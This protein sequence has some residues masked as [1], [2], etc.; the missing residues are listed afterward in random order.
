M[1]RKTLGITDDML[2]AAQALVDARA[3]E[4]I[5]RPQVENYQRLILAKH[6]FHREPKYRG[7]PDGHLPITD[8]NKVWLMSESDL[9]AYVAECHLERDRL[10]LLTRD[11]EGCP[12]L[13]AQARRT[14]AEWQLFQTLSLH[15]KLAHLKSANE[16][17][18]KLRQEAL[19]LSMKFLAPFLVNH[20]PSP[21][22]SAS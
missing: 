20:R 15:P 17:P 10:G 18:L 4:A 11:P 6:G 9:A 22:A 5:L 3:R 21:A 8:P 1:D 12:L 7:V 13:E 16:K 14:E 19:D 2:Q